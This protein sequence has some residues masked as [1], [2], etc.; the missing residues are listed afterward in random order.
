M[1]VMSTTLDSGEERTLVI[2]SSA[3]ERTPKWT[4]GSGNPPLSVAK[5]TEIALWWS[6]KHFARFDSAEI[7]SITLSNPGCFSTSKHWF[8]V[9]EFEPVLAGNRMYRPGNWAAVLMDGSIIETKSSK[10]SRNK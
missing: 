8:Y 1:K 4:P 3:L 5:A 10:G 9:F 6:K 7:K 2:D